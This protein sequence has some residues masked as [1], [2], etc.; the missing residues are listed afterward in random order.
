MAG[1]TAAVYDSVNATAVNLAG[2]TLSLNVAAGIGSGTFTILSVAGTSGGV[3]G[4]FNGLP[5]LGSVTVGGTQFTINYAGGD[6][7]DVVLTAAP[8]GGPGFAGPT[9]PS[10]V[11]TVL[12]GGLT[13]LGSTPAA[14]QHSMVDNVVYSFSQAV[15][16]LPNFTLSGFQ[17]TPALPVPNVNVSG[18]G[19]SGRSSFSGARRPTRERT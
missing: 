18:S 12:N 8:V 19:A 16:L 17:G 6:G 11:S 2:A 15:S 13:Y 4:A 7:N 14:H 9:S 5:N 3:T 10:I 1:T